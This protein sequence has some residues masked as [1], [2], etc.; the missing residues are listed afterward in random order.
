MLGAA[1]GDDDGSGR[2]GATTAQRLIGTW[3]L[4][5]FEMLVDGEVVGHPLG[6]DAVGQLT[7]TGD[8]RVTALLM[9]RDRPW[10]PDVDFLSATDAERGAAAIG[11]VAYGGRFEVADDTVIHHV[12][13]SLYVE[14]VGNPLTRTVSWDGEALILSTERQHTRSGRARWQRLV[15]ERWASR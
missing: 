1:P 4:V 13:L 3:D 5:A 11:F 9:R 14:H 12:E 10:S 7:Y 8:G 2:Q 6:P 15:W